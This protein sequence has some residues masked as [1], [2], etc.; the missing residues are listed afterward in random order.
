[1]DGYRAANSVVATLRGLDDLGAI[2]DAAAA[3]GGDHI[4]VS[5]LSFSVEDRTALEAA[6]R[7]LAWQDATTKARHLATL[8]G[9]TL[10]K[11][12]AVIEG[13][14]RPAPT[15]AM[16]AA[17]VAESS[18]PVEPGEVTVSVSLEVLFDA[19]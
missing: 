14:G 2:I 9:V 18:T 6:A 1:L 3:V 16:R 8:A 7:R 4:I 17:M 12:K 5:G 19:G 10:G 11:P 15:L 13:G